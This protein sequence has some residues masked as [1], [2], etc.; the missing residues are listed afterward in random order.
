VAGSVGPS[1]E[2]AERALR[3]PSRATPRTNGRRDELTEREIA[4]LRLLDGDLSR[5]EIADALYVSLDTVKTH[6]RG[7]YRKLGAG[8]REE[9]VAGARRRGLI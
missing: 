2:A 1:L 5:R 3:A 4:V 7:I 6:I 9:A 8:S